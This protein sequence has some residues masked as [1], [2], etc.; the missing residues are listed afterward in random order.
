MNHRPKESLKISTGSRPTRLHCKYHT[1]I[2]SKYPTLESCHSITN[3]NTS[4]WAATRRLTHSISFKWRSS[5]NLSAC[6]WH[7]LVTT[8]LKNTPDHFIYHANVIVIYIKCF[9]PLTMPWLTDTKTTSN[10]ENNKKKL[11]LPNTRS[12]WLNHFKKPA[13]YFLKQTHL[14]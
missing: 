4:W 13:S 1:S 11:T 14:L 2:L 7:H 5:L 10:T 9:S 3:R 8:S 12:K 6:I